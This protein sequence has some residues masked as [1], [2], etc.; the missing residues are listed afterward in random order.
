MHGY[1]HI[2]VRGG[3]VAKLAGEAVPP[4]VDV[5]GRQQ[6]AEAIKS[7]A[8]SDDC[9]GRGD[10]LDRYRHIGSCG[11]PVAELTVTVGP[12]ALHM[13]SR[14]HGAEAVAVGIAGDFLGIAYTSN[15]DW[16]GGAR[17]GPVAK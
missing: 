11:G 15:R 7:S 16:H 4:A 9:G 12:P 1:R 5:L 8:S 2:G 6:G 17:C 3:P 13:A 10:V 14:E